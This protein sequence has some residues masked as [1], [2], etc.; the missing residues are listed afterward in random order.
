VTGAAS[1][2]VSVYTQPDG[3][4]PGAFVKG[5][6]TPAPSAD[7]PAGTFTA[8]QGYDVYVTAASV[9]VVNGGRTAQVAASENTFAPASFV[10]R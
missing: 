10:G 8:G 5:L 7:F 2:Q 9:D 1:Y 3:F 6:W 4:T